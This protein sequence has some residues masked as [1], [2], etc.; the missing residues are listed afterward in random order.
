MNVNPE[1]KGAL[2]TVLGDEE[3]EYWIVFNNFYVVTRYN[4]SIKYALAVTILGKHIEIET[5]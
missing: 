2:V 4:P 1:L 3:Q 5:R